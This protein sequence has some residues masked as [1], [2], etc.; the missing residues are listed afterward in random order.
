M[1]P[2]Q[3]QNETEELVSLNAEDLSAEKLDDVELEDVAGGGCTNNC[4][5]NF[6]DNP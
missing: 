3:K 1:N 6:A 5:I 4:G 2:D